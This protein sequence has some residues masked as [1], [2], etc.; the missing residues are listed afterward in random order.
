MDALTRRDTLRLGL[1]AAG[2][3]L[4]PEWA[5]PALAQGEVDVPFTDFPANFVTS[6]ADGAPCAVS[7][8]GHEVCGEVGERDV[9]LALRQRGQC[10]FR[11]ECQSS[12]RQAQSQRVASCD[13]VHGSPSY[14]R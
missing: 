12:R 9:N 14:R 5:L 6:P 13:L 1:S 11:D 7:R 3:A 4:I 8:A 10:P 2:L